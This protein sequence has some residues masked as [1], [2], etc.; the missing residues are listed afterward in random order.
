M[1]GFRARADG[2]G[3]KMAA[4]ARNLI[5]KRPGLAVPRAI[6]RFKILAGVHG[7]RTHPGRDHRPASVLKFG[8]G[9]PTASHQ[10]DFAPIPY[11]KSGRDR[12]L[13][14]TPCQAVT[15]LTTNSVTVL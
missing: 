15:A 10:I 12:A 11:L 13:D 8:P 1:P 7:S 6:V 5:R 2:Y 3:G 4:I 14:P 9:R